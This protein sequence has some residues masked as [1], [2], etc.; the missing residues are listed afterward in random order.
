MTPRERRWRTKR[1]VS[2]DFPMMRGINDQAWRAD[3][4][5]SLLAGRLAHVNLIPLNPTPGYPMVGSPLTQ[6]LAAIAVGVIIWVALS[7]SQTGGLDLGTFASYV[8]ALLTLLERIKSLSG[9]NAAVQ[10]GL[11]AAETFQSRN[12]SNSPAPASGSQGGIRRALVILTIFSAR[13]S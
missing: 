11:A 9:V 7:Q 3:R 4:L 12:G 5:G 13:S 1:R 10:R 6:V 2:I 8:V